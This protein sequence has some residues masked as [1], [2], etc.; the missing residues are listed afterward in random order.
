[1]EEIAPYV[2]HRVNI[3]TTFYKTDPIILEYCLPTGG[4]F[5]I[6]VAHSTI[7]L[8]QLFLGDE[9]Y[10]KSE[11]HGLEPIVTLLLLSNEFLD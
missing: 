8:G 11:F 7:L 3:Y 1:M 2:G 6:L 9:V 5:E 10:N 4:T